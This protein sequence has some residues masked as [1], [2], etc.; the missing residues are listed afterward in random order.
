V[1]ANARLV[2]NFI[3]KAIRRQAVRLLRDKSFTKQDLMLLT[4]SELMEAAFDVV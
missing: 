1:P 3:E 4:S 2:R